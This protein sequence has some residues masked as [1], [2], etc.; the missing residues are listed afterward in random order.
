M[1]CM[2]GTVA[3]NPSSLPNSP[4]FS[5]FASLMGPHTL[6]PQACDTLTPNLT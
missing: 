1:H 6:A 2:D 4:N 5:A 3:I